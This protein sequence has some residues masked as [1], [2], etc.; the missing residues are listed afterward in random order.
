M[1]A[2]PQLEPEVEI[3]PPTHEA[4]PENVPARDLSPK[5]WRPGVKFISKFRDYRLVVIEE[6][7]DVVNGIRKRNPG[8][9]AEFHAGEWTPKDEMQYN[10]VAEKWRQMYGHLPASAPNN[11]CFIEAPDVAELVPKDYM[12]EKN[13]RVVEVVVGP[14]TVRATSRGVPDRG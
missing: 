13:T 9:T 14:R 7:V 5:G 12:R 8:F 4:R 11:Y 1:H 3:E 10:L 2:E 6:S